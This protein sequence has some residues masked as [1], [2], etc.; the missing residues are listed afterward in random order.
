MTV[1][2]DMGFPPQMESAQPEMDGFDPGP[3]GLVKD[4]RP[5]ASHVRLGAGLRVRLTAIK[6]VT[7][8]GVL[9]RRLYL[10]AVLNEVTV[11]TVREHTEFT[12]HALGEFS[13]PA[14]GGRRARRL[15]DLPFEMLTLDWDADWLVEYRHPQVVQDAL[16]RIIESMRP[17]LLLAIVRFG[18]GRPVEYR[19]AVTLRRTQRTLKPGETDTRY[20]TLEFK[21]WRALESGRLTLQGG[22]QGRR[23]HDLPARHEL[24]A[25]TNLEGL[26]K[27][28]YGTTAHW[29]LIRD[30]NHL[31]KWGPRTPLVDHR[32]YKVGD[33]IRIPR[34]PQRPGGGG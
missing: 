7:P 11:E 28:Y 32:R 5:G 31:G 10:P 16:D 2:R 18:S 4:P 23:G 25:E 30:H 27:L 12:T 8:G 21:E 33:V 1:A 34:L 15:Q 20:W 17:V 29:R 9:P 24:K 6:G 26:S 14:Q 19:G 22:T 13:V 3:D